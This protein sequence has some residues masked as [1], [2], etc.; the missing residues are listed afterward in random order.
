MKITMVFADSR[1]EVL[2][3]ID[4]STRESVAFGPSKSE[5]SAPSDAELERAIVDAVA[6]GAGGRGE[7][8]RRELEERRRGRSVT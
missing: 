1:S 8:A 5:R 4:G 3:R 7:Y 2:P 6:M